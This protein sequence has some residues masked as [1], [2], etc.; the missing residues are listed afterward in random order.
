M[1]NLTEDKAL[2]GYGNRLQY[3]VTEALAVSSTFA[4][5]IGG[6][7]V[8]DSS[9]NALINPAGSVH[10]LI[11]STGPN[12]VGAYSRDGKQVLPCTGNGLDLENCNTTTD[13]L[14]VYRSASSSTSGGTT[15]YDDM[16]KYYSA[17]DIPLWKAQSPDSP[18]IVDNINAASDPTRHIGIG[19]AQPS[20]HNMVQV[21][22][23]VRAQPDASA[24]T[25]PN[26]GSLKVVDSICKDGSDD[27]I[28]DS[29]FKPELIAGN[30]NVGDPKYSDEN[31]TNMH[32]PAGQYVKSIAQGKVTCTSIPKAVCP[33]GQW[34]VGVNASGELIC[35]SSMP[36]PDCKSYKDTICNSPYTQNVVVP[37]GMIGDIFRVQPV[38]MTPSVPNDYLAYYDLICSKWGW[39]CL[40]WAHCDLGYCQAC[41][42]GAVST[43]A[44]CATAGADG[45]WTG[46]FQY[47]DTTTC[48][49]YMDIVTTDNFSTM[50]TC[51]TGAPQTSTGSC[52]YGQIGV[53]TYQRDWVCSSATKGKWSSWTQ[54]ASTCAP[55]PS[56]KDVT[57]YRWKYDCPAG[58][59]GKG[60]QQSRVHK[61]DDSYTSWA[62]TGTVDCTPTSSCTPQTGLK[63]WDGVCGTGL[64][65][66]GREYTYDI[67]CSGTTSVKTN[68]VLT[69]ATDCAAHTWQTVSTAISGPTATKPTGVPKK[70]DSCDI[71]TDGSGSCYDSGYYTYNCTCQ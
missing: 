1:L 28:C 33:K 22:G 58:N 34:L 32:C 46:T 26:S 31:A 52:P 5:D 65:G 29:G 25:D 71:N 2:D 51:T 50:C 62:N 20:Q 7:A 66:Q 70:G 30:N 57:E 19:G 13:N 38:D 36:I 53:I 61:C 40:D 21:Y 18:N 11:F 24:V 8:R 16:V 44:D 43:N 27:T 63:G 60:N 17:V 12:L 59:T 23:S 68:I 4:R 56:C 10:Y 41:V 47:T 6:I 55:D 37:S 67:T 3:A 54:V 48:S 35:A 39:K 9:G 14:A 45:Y 64:S 15:G 42:D 49:P 69:G